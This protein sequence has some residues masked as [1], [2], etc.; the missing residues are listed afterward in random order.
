MKTIKYNDN[1]TIQLT[2]NSDGGLVVVVQT[3]PGTYPEQSGHDL[4]IAA[5]EWA[6]T[7]TIE[8]QNQ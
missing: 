4:A 5:N 1:Y 8:E 3:P 6:D 7:F 2:E